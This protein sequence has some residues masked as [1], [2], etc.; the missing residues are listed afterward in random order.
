MEQ[1]IRE[2]LKPTL[3]SRAIFAGSRHSGPQN[4]KNPNLVYVNASSFKNNQNIR[5]GKL[6]LLVVDFEQQ[7]ATTAATKHRWAFEDPGC[8]LW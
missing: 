7:C 8:T 4:H 6:P 1:S 3:G 5:F 2:L